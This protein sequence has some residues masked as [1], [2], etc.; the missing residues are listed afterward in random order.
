MLELW[1]S[2]LSCYFKLQCWHRMKTSIWFQ[3]ALPLIQYP[4]NSLGKTEEY[5]SSA[6]APGTGRPRWSSCKCLQKPGLVWWKL[7][8]QNSSWFL[9]CMVGCKYPSYNPQ[10]PSV[11][12]G[13]AAKEGLDST[14]SSQ[15][16]VYLAMPQH[17]PDDSDLKTHMYTFPGNLVSLMSLAFSLRKF[18]TWCFLQGILNKYL[19]IRINVNLLKFYP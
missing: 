16:V 18:G 2:G 6:W 4:T 8:A 14:Q 10:L 1:F 3:A 19:Q 12:S 5:G 15:A 13:S 7:G 17:L 9:Y 11:Q